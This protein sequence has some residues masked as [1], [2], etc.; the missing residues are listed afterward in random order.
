MELARWLLLDLARWLAV[1]RAQVS[2]HGTPRAPRTVRNTLDPVARALRGAVFA[3]RLAADPSAS[4]PTDVRPQAEDADPTA[5]A[6]RRLA[7]AE[8]ETL[9][10]EPSVAAR[11]SI[12]WHLLLLT[13]AREAEVIALRWSD[14]LPDAPLA[15]VRLATQIH[16]RTRE[17]SPTKTRAVKDVPLHPTLAAALTAWRTEGWPEEY[18]CAPKASDLVVPARGRPGRHAGVAAGVGGALWQQDI[19][20]AL[21]RDLLACG[22]PPHRVHDLR[23]TFVSLCADF[24]VSPEIAARWTHAPLAT[25][26]SRH[27]Y[28]VPAWSR[29]C[30]EILRLRVTPR[31][32]WAT[33]NGRPQKQEPETA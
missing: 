3:G 22:L 14:I 6:T 26:G 23:H 8:V 28:L 27:L 33:G 20:R 12:V 15:R 25:A 21:Q 24:G 18:G 19:H 1:V 11:W 17:R 29:Q 16:H 13:G 31:T 2:V 7:L 4:L 5:H 10:G 9:L 30:E 32:Q